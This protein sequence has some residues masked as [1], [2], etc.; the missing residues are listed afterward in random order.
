MIIDKVENLQK[1]AALLPGLPAAIEAL[2]ALPSR[3]PGH[4]E[5]P[6]GYFMIQQGETRPFTEAAFEAHRRNIDVQIV[7]DGGEELAWAAASNLRVVKAYDADKDVEML[8]G[9]ARAEML[10]TAGMFYIMLPQDAHLPTAH[11]ATPHRYL[12]AVIKLPAD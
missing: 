3:T 6:G 2:Q 1:Y 9:A 11:R 4:Y 8:E 5:F 7:L 10:I 12:K